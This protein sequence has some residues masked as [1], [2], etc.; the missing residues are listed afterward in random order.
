MRRDGETGR[1]LEVLKFR[2][3]SSLHGRHPM[4]ITDEGVIV[5]P[6][7][8]TLHERPSQPDKGSDRRLSVGVRS[9]DGML[10]GGLPVGTTTLVLGATGTG[11]TLLGAH[12][13]AGSSAAEPGL[14]FGFYEQPERLLQNAA[15]VGLDLA[16]P[17]CRGDLELLWYPTT[18]QILDDLGG[19]L[20]RAVG[21]RGVKRLLVD[22]LGGYVEAADNSARA[23]KVFAAL[24]HE[25][26]RPGRHHDLHRG[27]AEPGGA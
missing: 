3:S 15:S 26:A 13:L 2:G 25:F 9:V 27:D 4:R 5:Y 8:E 19:Q 16:G 18:G 17:V 7:I 14:H 23:G 22:G 20:L 11:K 24:A 21:R 1:G 10:G 6:R 12:F